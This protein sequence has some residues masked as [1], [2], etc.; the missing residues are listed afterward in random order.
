MD[1]PLNIVV[2]EDHDSM[3]EITMEAL[4]EKGHRVIGV[5]CAE[6][7]GELTDY[8]RI[9]LMVIDLNLPGEDG[10]SLANRIRKDQP[11]IGIV[12]LTSRNGPKETLI[13]YENGADIY[14]TKPISV[15]ILN[16][17]VK[18]L[19]RRIYPEDR[20]P[21]S[22]QFD[23]SKRV[24]TSES[25]SVDLTLQEATLLSALIRAQGHFLE[26]WQLIE[27]LGNEDEEYN[28]GSLEVQIFRLRKKLSKVCSE[29]QPIKVIRLLGY[30]LCINI[31]L[32]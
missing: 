21:T 12:M 8:L 18:S 27:L 3:R 10:I 31:K 1:T 15:D 17:A 5:D 2:V 14:L 6:A 4:R 30:Q 20:N 16:A 22:L 26:N 23:M 9:D 11:G 19:S 32:V 28:K 29:K 13:G 24:L 25:V 7:L